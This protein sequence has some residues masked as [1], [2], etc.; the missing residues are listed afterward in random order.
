M[1]IGSRGARAGASAHRSTCR[2]ARV[3]DG[4][5]GDPDGARR[6]Q[7]HGDPVPTAAWA[8]TVPA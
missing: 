4:Q 3:R 2:S 7:R 5:P 1:L 8:A 6:P